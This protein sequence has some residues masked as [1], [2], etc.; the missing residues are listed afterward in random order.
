MSS[1]HSLD[2]RYLF[3]ELPAGVSV[4]FVHAHKRNE[5]VYIILSGK[6]RFFIDG[7]EFGAEAGDVVRIDPTGERCI[8]ADDQETIKFV[9]IQAE[10]NSLVQFTKNDGV[11]SEA[12]PSWF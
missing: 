1:S 9:C 11:P 4:P 8:K 5:E 7:D 12:K 3:N 2:A 10:A 6:G